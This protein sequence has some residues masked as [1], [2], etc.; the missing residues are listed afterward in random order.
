MSDDEMHSGASS[1]EEEIETEKGAN[2]KIPPYGKMVVEAI[3]EQQTS[4]NTGIS[5]AKI[6]EY[7]KTKYHLEDVNAS[8]LKNA[9]KKAEEKEII[10]HKTGN[11]FIL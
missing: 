5:R 7:I 10:E 4:W 11:Y 6:V 3:R 8:A 2:K 1:G 9:I